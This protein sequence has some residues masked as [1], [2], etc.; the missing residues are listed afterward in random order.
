M[1]VVADINTHD[2]RTIGELF[3]YSCEETK[4]ISIYEV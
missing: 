3:Y 4:Y 1:V 2:S